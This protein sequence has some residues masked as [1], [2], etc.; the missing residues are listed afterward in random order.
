MHHD[1]VQDHLLHSG[2]STD[3]RTFLQGA[4]KVAA[5]AAALGAGASSVPA[6]AAAPTG[7]RL[8]ESEGA[9][10]SQT[11]RKGRLMLDQVTLDT[12]K[13]H[14]NT[15]F[16][17]VPEGQEPVEVKLVEAEAMTTGKKAPNPYSFQLLFV[18]PL[19]PRLGQ[20]IYRIEHGE[21]D[22][23]DIF[24]VPIGEDGSGR[25]YEAIFNRRI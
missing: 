20:G 25:Q 4:G 19:T 10:V 9:S 24:L 1:R 13:P 5:V 3:R 15:T 21:I 8:D 17:L 14:L 6:R 12:F 22:P 23:L 16:R 11:A 2:A 7:S 18:G